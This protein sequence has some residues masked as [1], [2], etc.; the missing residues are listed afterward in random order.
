[1]A[2]ASLN[3]YNLNAFINCPFDDDYADLFSAIVFTVH[4][5]GFVA[6]C[7]QE[8]NNAGRVRVDKILEIIG[9][10]RVGIHDISRVAL[11]LKS[12]LPRF[13]MP[14]ELGLFLGA[15]QYGS[16]RQKDK[17]CLV[18]EKERYRFRCFALTSGDRTFPRTVER[19]TGSLTPSAIFFAV[20]GRP[21]KSRDQPP[22]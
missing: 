7:A 8:D 16:G 19:W 20:P 10:C 4:D 21:N 6:R 12:K 5:C 17:V 18:L 3:K 9:E 1:M 11:D 15:K 2:V 13:N 22:S 14:L